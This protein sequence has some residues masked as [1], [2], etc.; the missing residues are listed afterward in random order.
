MMPKNIFLLVCVAFHSL[1][2][3]AHETGDSTS[4]YQSET[5]LE[6]HKIMEICCFSQSVPGHPGEYYYVYYLKSAPYTHDVDVPFDS[7]TKK[8]IIRSNL[9]D[10]KGIATE[11]LKAMVRE[12]SLS[13]PKAIVYFVE[14]DANGVVTS[15]KVLSSIRLRKILRPQEMKRFL[16]CLKDFRF[17]PSAIDK[18][19]T[20]QQ[21]VFP[22]RF[23]KN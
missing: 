9:Q 3:V 7:K 11:T 16:T 6:Y 17:D 13:L 22:I 10:A 19:D 1:S 20:K 21:W 12:H 2:L 18:R 15:T 14:F 8:D 23:N 5:R 4:L